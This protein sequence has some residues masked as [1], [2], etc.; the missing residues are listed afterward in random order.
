MRKVTLS[1]L[2][3]LLAGC[4]SLSEEQCLSTDWRAIGFEDGA[5]GAPASALPER[6]QTCT[7]RG[8][9]A[10]DMPAYLAG[11]REGL[12]TYCTL[13]NGFAV[14]ASGAADADVC[15]GE[16][17]ALFLAGYSRGARL[18][19]L[20]AAVIRASQA[21]SDAQ[22]AL[23]ETK[24]RISEAET[25]ILST[26]T[27]HEERAELAA[28]LKV[29]KQ[30]RQRTEAAITSLSQSKSSAEDDLAAFRAAQMAEGGAADALRPSNASYTDRP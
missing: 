12:Q 16:E 10:F 1:V 9:A 19:A 13:E 3:A 22:A 21:L 28:E 17:R 14:G 26:A 4:A 8:A 7:K 6:R 5:K 27:P 2:I 24:R 20:E 11:R 15:D 18:F 29:L 25:S 30:D 23:W